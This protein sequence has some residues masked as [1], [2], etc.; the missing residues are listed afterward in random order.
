MDWQRNAGSALAGV[1]A[2][3]AAVWATDLALT[4]WVDDLGL[5]AMLGTVKGGWVRGAG[6]QPDALVAMVL[7]VPQH[8]ATRPSSPDRVPARRLSAPA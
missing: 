4:R 6:Q 8:K 3:V 7:E 5:R 2:V 1:L